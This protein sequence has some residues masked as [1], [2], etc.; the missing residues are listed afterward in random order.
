MFLQIEFK[1]V[2]EDAMLKHLQESRLLPSQMVRPKRKTVWDEKASLGK[3]KVGDWVEVQYAYAP[4]TCSD[5]GV[6]CV[7]GIE[8]ALEEN[9]GEC[10]PEDSQKGNY[11]LCISFYFTLYS[12]TSVC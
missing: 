8:D 6:G 12:M 4:G 10:A 2:C 3:L 11:R 7:I 9:D 5:G 1:K